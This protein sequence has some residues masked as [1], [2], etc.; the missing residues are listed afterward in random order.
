M[1]SGIRVDDKAM[2]DSR[3]YELSVFPQPSFLWNIM[4]AHQ[5][6]DS[7][8]AHRSPLNFYETVGF[9]YTCDIW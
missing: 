7:A 8:A 2:Y 3:L 1:A 6:T 4:A 9:E 5:A